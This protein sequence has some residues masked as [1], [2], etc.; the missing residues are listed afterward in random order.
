MRSR[1]ML[2]TVALVASLALAVSGCGD[3][4]DTASGSSSEPKKKEFAAGTTMARL[5]EAG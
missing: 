5:Q 4:D 2:S 1:R 3:D